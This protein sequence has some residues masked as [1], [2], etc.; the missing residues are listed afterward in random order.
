MKQEIKD[1][2]TNSTSAALATTGPKGLN[3]VPI[4]VFSVQDEEIHLYDFFMNKTSE[5][6]KAEPKAVFTCWK[7]FVGIQVKA[8]VAYETEG[9]VYEATV[10]EMK[11]KFPDRTLAAVIRLTPTEIY[12]VAPGATGDDLVL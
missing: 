2:I 6:L 11:E 12:D 9:E 1:I 8:D 7:E 3:I 10:T 4:S 5:N